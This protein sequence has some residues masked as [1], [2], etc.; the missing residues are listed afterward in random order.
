MTALR[1]EPR[2][3][4]PDDFY[5]RLIAMHAG[6][7]DA[8]SHKLNA[9]LILVLANHVGDEAVIDEAMAVARATIV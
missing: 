5:E 6:L 9:S 8:D 7:G 1:T 4:R 2:L 3:A